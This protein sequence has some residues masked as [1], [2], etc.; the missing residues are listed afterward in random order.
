[1]GL[2]VLCWVMAEQPGKD[3]TKMFDTMKV[4]RKIKQA[5]VERNMTQMDLADAMGVSYQAVSNWERGNSMP[6]ISKLE[7]L[8]RVVELS[9]GELLGVESRETRAVEKMLTQENAALTV[10]ELSGIAPLLPPEQMKE[11]T[12]KHSEENTAWNLEAIVEMAPFLDDVFLDEIVSNV[13]VKSLAELKALAPFLSEETLDRLVRK[14]PAADGKGIEEL[15]PFLKEETLDYLAKQC[16]GSV[17][18]EMLE[19]LAPFLSE[20]TLDML[21]MD[22][23]HRGDRKKL[24]KLYPFLGEDALHEIARELMRLGDMNGLREAAPFL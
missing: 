14:A 8:C 23:L 10:E 16:A 18:S 11:R 2:P 4:A 9:I 24:S 7:Q 17:D 21:A 5:R 6:D 19:N 15:L 22:C 20:E 3:G 13:E 1:M 12:R